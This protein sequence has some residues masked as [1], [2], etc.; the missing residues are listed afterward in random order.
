M[1]QV[2]EWA[3]VIGPDF[4]EEKEWEAW[5]GTPPSSPERLTDSI[6]WPSQFEGSR[7]DKEC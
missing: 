7:Y 4:E 1:D 5:Q 2:N 6:M 3:E